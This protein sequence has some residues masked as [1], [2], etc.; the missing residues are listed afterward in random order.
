MQESEL[1]R[2][3]LVGQR[4]IIVLVI[5][6]IIIIIIIKDRKWS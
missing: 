6:I 3:K 1:Q 4:G 2:N 5:T